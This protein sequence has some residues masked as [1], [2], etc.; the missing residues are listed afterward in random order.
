MHAK[1]TEFVLFL[2]G[3]PESNQGFSAKDF[4][5]LGQNYGIT[6]KQI[7]DTFLGKQ[8]AIRAG[9]YPAEIGAVP[10]G[11]KAASKKAASKK[12][13]SKKAASKKAA[14]KVTSTA[15]ADFDNDVDKIIGDESTG[16][17]ENTADSF[18]WIATPEEIAGELIHQTNY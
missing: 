12:A 17:V 1:I 18:V 7:K 6:C 16:V 15:C 13:A 8:R 3:L 5:K 2:Q 4:Y 14:R 10:L 11:K 9:R